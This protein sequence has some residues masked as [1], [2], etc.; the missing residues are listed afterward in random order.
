M[1]NG[2]EKLI[3]EIPG[4]EP[5]PTG[6]SYQNIVKTI[7]AA[8]ARP[9]VTETALPSIAGL[10][11]PG[12]QALSPYESAIRQQTQAGVAQAQTA[13][14]RRGLTGSDIELANLAR[15]RGKGTEALASLYGKTA[16]QLANFMFQAAT[17]DIRAQRQNLIMLAQAMGQELTSQRD[18][19]MFRM[20]LQEMMAQSQRSQKAGLF[21]AGIGAF[22]KI[23]GAGLGAALGPGGAFAGGAAG[24][25]LG[26][27]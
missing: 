1:P 21:G 9:G 25:A 15:E 5:G 13:A 6:A 7:Q 18:M 20:Q 17:G 3:P 16:N 19:E 12:G 22:G 24:G 14:M 11:A 4:I 23:F 2:M 27:D 8:G 26:G 10:L